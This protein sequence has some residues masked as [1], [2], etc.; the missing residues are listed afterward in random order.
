MVEMWRKKGNNSKWS[1]TKKSKF[2]CVS[3]HE[4]TKRVPNSVYGRPPR[5]VSSDTS[6]ELSLLRKNCVSER[7]ATGSARAKSENTNEATTTA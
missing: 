3:S 2:M 5:V 6:H 7:L 1:N 4:G